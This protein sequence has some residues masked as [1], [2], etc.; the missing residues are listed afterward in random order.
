MDE[1]FD[2]APQEEMSEDFDL[3]DDG[4]TLKVGKEKEIG[5][6]GLKKK[7]LKE[8]EGWDTPKW[9]MKSKVVLGPAF[10][11]RFEVPGPRHPAFGP[12]FE[13]PSFRPPFIVNDPMGDQASTPNAWRPMHPSN[14]GPSSNTGLHNLRP[15]LLP[16]S[17]DMD[18]ALAMNA[19]GP[20][21][22]F[23][24]P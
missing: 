22:G 19:G 6:Q 9:A 15:P 12:R 23:G 20:G 24:G 16:R 8:G 1:D 21:N 3:P 4:S 5:K 7:L 14:M 11:S 13:V 17:G 2:M 10:G 18:M